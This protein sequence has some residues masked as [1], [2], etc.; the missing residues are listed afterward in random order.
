MNTNLYNI[1]IADGNYRYI[2]TDPETGS[3]INCILDL[4]NKLIVVGSANSNLSS[5]SAAYNNSEEWT[6]ASGSFA[7]NHAVNSIYIPSYVKHIEST[8]FYN[9]PN[10][11]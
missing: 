1:S 6:L 3:N 2:S 11:N 10:L 4:D 5:Y 7:K 8:A 9:C